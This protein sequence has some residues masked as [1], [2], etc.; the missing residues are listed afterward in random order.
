MNF[1]FNPELGVLWP[2]SK[3]EPAL[4]Q[5]GAWVTSPG[6][7]MNNRQQFCL[8]L[9][10]LHKRQSNRERKRERAG[11]GVRMSSH[12]FHWLTPQMVTT[13]RAGPPETRIRQSPNK[14][15]WGSASCPRYP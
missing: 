14:F 15:L 3:A 6:F 12:G 7:I 8:R 13:S 9:F 2:A 10:I 11:M 1:A 4:L 5:R